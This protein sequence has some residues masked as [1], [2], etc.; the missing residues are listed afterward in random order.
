VYSFI[1]GL[2][3]GSFGR[4]GWLIFLFFIWGCKPLQLF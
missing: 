1:D 4:S 2:V 3:P